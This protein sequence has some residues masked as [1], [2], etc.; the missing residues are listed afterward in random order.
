MAGE[1]SQGVWG[2]S[3]SL[4]EA[5]QMGPGLGKGEKRD[6]TP[7]SF[8]ASCMAPTVCDDVGIML[9]CLEE[10]GGMPGRVQFRY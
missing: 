6:L 3:S 10:A 5:F 2:T 7:T 8:I 9:R 1:A 4:L